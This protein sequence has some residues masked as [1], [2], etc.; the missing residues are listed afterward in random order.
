MENKSI[1]EAVINAQNN[2]KNIERSK[3]GYGYKY[4]PLEKVIEHVKPILK[5]HGLA[6]M[7][8]LGNDE[9]GSV[10]V[11][12]RLIH[13]SGESL[14]SIFSLPPTA[15]KQANDA[16]KMGASITYARRYAL[17][18]ILN[19]SADE[20]V[21]ASLELKRLNELDAIKKV[22]AQYVS[23]RGIDKKDVKQFML[24]TQVNLND[25][26]SLT[27][28]I[29]DSEKLQPMIDE[30]KKNL[31][32][33]NIEEEI[34]GTIEATKKIQEGANKILEDKKKDMSDSKTVVSVSVLQ[35]NL[36]SLIKEHGITKVENIYDYIDFLEIDLTNEK[37]LRYYLNNPDEIKIGIQN[38]IVAKNS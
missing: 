27:D 3:D 31:R 7:Q 21:D 22:V 10:S 4:A 6:I 8:F 35:E 1:Y 38:Y 19:I 12:T 29:V 11:E 34:K 33:S 15:L 28:L 13:I 25:I 20:D 18:S 14:S 9:N 30:F 32:K 5:D 23:K 17:M 36:L 2:L 24:S 26:Q 16:Q 37:S